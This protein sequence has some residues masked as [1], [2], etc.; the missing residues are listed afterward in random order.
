M[1]LALVASGEYLGEG[2]AGA[3][4]R[5]EGAHVTDPQAGRLHKHRPSELLNAGKKSTQRN[6]SS[7]YPSDPDTSRAHASVCPLLRHL[8]D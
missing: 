6:V 8:P 3:E 4:V 1:H 2:W 7:G 5:K